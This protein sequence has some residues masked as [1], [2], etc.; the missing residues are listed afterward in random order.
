MRTLS[1]EE[2]HRVVSW[3]GSGSAAAIDV[4]RDPKG[5]RL[6]VP[7]DCTIIIPE[8]PQSAQCAELAAL[9]KFST[10]RVGTAP[11]DSLHW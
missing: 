7:I 2:R 11:V 6:V 10:N 3:D 9:A 5:T 4:V 8:V 1:D